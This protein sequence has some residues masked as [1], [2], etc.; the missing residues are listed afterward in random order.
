MKEAVKKNVTR[1]EMTMGRALFPTNPVLIVDDEEIFLKS[2][3]FLLRFEGINNLVTCR[4][5]RQIQSLLAGQRF[6]LVLLD[7]MMPFVSG[8][9]ILDFI[10]ADFPDLPV[11]VITAENRLEKAVE[12][13]KAGAYDY[14]V[15]PVEENKLVLTVKN[16]IRLDEVRKENLLLKNSFTANKLAHPE[17]FREIITQD[18]KMRAVF[19]YV[20]AL[21]QTH[22]PILVTGETGTGKELL[23]RA[24][25]EL[26]GR[27][28]KFVAFNI[29]AEDSALISDTLFGH[30]RGGFTGAVVGRKGLIEQAVGGTL[31]L[32]E[33]GDLNGDMQVKLL[34]LLQEKRYYPIGSDEEKSTDAR[35]IFATNQD[36]GSLIA[37]KKFRKD[38]YYRLVSHHIQIPPLRERR[39][40]IPLLLDHILT[41]SAQALGKRVPTVPQELLLLL[42][43]YPFPG[44]VR[45]LEGM[46]FDAMSR[47]SRGVLAMQ[48]FL[49]KIRPGQGQGNARESDTH[50]D[51]GN[52]ITA[53]ADRFP[54]LK[55]MEDLL[56][57]LALAKASGNQTIAA[58]LLGVSRKALNNRL[59]R[60]KRKKAA[61]PGPGNR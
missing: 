30:S 28:G 11:V 40:D 12:C 6:S 19:Q 55:E 56:V 37:E 8:Q 33:I 25:H 31:F 57:D 29:A 7:L 52:L 59:I 2:A 48:T 53:L 5:S 22:L 4:D 15:K 54:T 14:I 9:E 60:A 35:F 24:I 3:E 27:R 49:E 13:I 32:D 43:N 23:A 51:A 39:N 21:A 41:R 42:K 18:N 17:V 16:L 46:I 47:H 50:W 44:N 36:L 10:A 45:E 1:E 61:N 34:R 26:S 38:L 58:Q 20:E